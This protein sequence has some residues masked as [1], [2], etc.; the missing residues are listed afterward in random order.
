MRAWWRRYRHWAYRVGLVLAVLLAAAAS[1]PV[2]RTL[3][4]LMGL[5]VNVGTMA[6]LMIVQVVFYF[7][8]LMYY[9]GGTKTVKIM[10][11]Q[12]GEVTFDDY[13][14][15][16]E[17][18][19]VAR[20]WVELL[21]HPEELRRMGGQPVT[22][23][24]LSGPPGSG[25][26]YLAKA[27]AGEAAVPFLG[28]DGSRLI[29]MWLG[30]GSIKVSRL[31]ATARRYARRYGACVVFVDELDS[32]GSTRGGVA[33][34]TQTGLFGGMPWFGGG[35]G[36][37]NTLLTEL[38]G[39]NEPRGWFKTRWY[40]L[41]GRKLPPPDYWVM[42]IGAT[43]RP[44]V[45]DPA[46]T[47]AGRLDI[48]IRVDPTD[49]DGRREV[50]KGYVGRVRC[51]EPI[52]VDGFAADTIGLTPADL[53]SII[54][55]RAPALALRE[56]RSGIT[57]RDLQVALTE[58]TMGLRQPIASI[59][60]EDRRAIAYH[61]AGHAVVTWALTQDKITRASV[62]RYSGGPSGGASL[63]H[64]YPVPE[65]ERVGAR[66]S[67][68]ARKICVALASRAAEIEFL[69][70]PHMGGT[71]DMM[72]VRALLLQLAEEGVFSSLGYSMQPTPELVAEM[73]R[74]KDQLLE[75]ARRVL[76]Q[77][78]DNP[79]DWYPWGEEALERA[80]REDKPIFLSIGYSTCHWC[81]VMAHECFENPE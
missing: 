75:Q 78:A 14:G 72:R 33:G 19:A 55:R 58:E 5:A 81:H 6:A 30:V 16:P 18:L 38:D 26:T 37:L 9:L 10:P 63:G 8:F 13:W 53:M 71:S 79:V 61:E 31:Y 23:V 70:E 69:G 27:M 46:L 1:A 52:D 47:R 43:N 12:A 45:L 77:H 64:I 60:D 50:I 59:L 76:R 40:R 73:D 48:K 54:V 3:F 42:T 36:V 51:L 56:G 29:S 24:L 39:I 34:Q 41:L 17:L 44:D 11:G 4:L 28:L 25:K 57:N 22:G 35:V 2:M 32:I 62:V 20:Q 80:R 74:Y 15:Q 21:S 66:A 67:D 65:K 68:I 7:G 49:R